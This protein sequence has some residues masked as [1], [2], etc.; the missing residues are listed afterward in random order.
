MRLLVQCPRG[1][2]PA[3]PGRAPPCGKMGGVQD[4][5]LSARAGKGYCK[6]MRGVAKR[7]RDGCLKPVQE[8]Q[9]RADMHRPQAHLPQVQHLGR[10][11]LHAAHAHAHHAPAAPRMLR[12]NTL[13]PKPHRSWLEQAGV[14]SHTKPMESRV[15]LLRTMSAHRCGR[16]RAGAQLLA[17]PVCPAGLDRKQEAGRAVQPKAQFG[18][19]RRPGLWVVGGVPSQLHRPARAPPCRRGRSQRSLGSLR[20]IRGSESSAASVVRA[21]RGGPVNHT[22]GP[23]TW[24]QH[25]PLASKVRE[26]DLPAIVREGGARSALLL[27]LL[28]HGSPP[29]SLHQP[30]PAQ[31]CRRLPAPP[32]QSSGLVCG[33]WCAFSSRG[34]PARAA[35]AAPVLPFL[36]AWFRSPGKCKQGKSSCELCNLKNSRRAAHDCQTPSAPRPLPLSLVWAEAG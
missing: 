13:L 9:G 31:G 26:H 32:V 29:P 10:S 23:P 5:V 22:H 2:C 16:G 35:P 6:C 33:P 30:S 27:L 19:G 1:G 4:R 28:L 17:G 21:S 8:Q 11:T 7:P 12:T 25:I 24:V 36:C 3:S 20:L 18:R 15:G 14:L 34:F